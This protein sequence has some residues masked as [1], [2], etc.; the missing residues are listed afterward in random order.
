MRRIDRQSGAAHGYDVCDTMAAE[1]LQRGL[2]FTKDGKKLEGAD[3]NRAEL[4]ER[5]ERF[6]EH[7]RRPSTAF[8]KYGDDGLAVT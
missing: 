6:V 2:S 8:R 3:A 5:F 1:V 7:S 4:R